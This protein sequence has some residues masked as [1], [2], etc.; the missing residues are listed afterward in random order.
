MK[1]IIFTF[2]DKGGA[3]KSVVA[4]VLA[5]ALI[6]SGKDPLLVDADPTVGHLLKF[7]GARDE[8]GALIWPQPATGVRT[9]ALHGNDDDR[10]QFG[11]IVESGRDLIL[12]D[13]P[14]AS[15]TLLG[16]IEANYGL[17]A[18]AHDAGYDVTLIISI[19]P[20]ESS[21]FAV[22]D[23]AALDPRADLVVVRNGGFGDLDKHFIVW[24]G[25]DEDEIAE[26][27]GKAAL[28]QRGLEIRLPDLDKGTLAL[29]GALRLPFR[30]AAGDGAYGKFLKLGPRRRQVGRFL[31]EARVQ[32]ES[33]G[34]PLGF[35][36]VK[37]RSAA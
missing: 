18:W 21:M 24:D 16:K 27:P 17:L 10:T 29:I 20:D 30:A 14:A 2:G 28:R 31:E 32:F 22:E 26:H 13:M 12:V 36:D 37:K 25:S 15:A 7:L 9:Y 5:E 35:G 19:T 3:G 8:S 1:R 6:A 4:R 33:V 11:E 34:T 23:A